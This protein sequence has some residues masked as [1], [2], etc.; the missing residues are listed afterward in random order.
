MATFWN[1]MSAEFLKLRHS[2]ALRLIWLFPALFLVLEFLFF[3]RPMLSLKVQSPAFSASFDTQQLKIIG[4]LWA[5]FFHPLLAALLP[6]LLFRNEHRCKVWRHLHAMPVPRRSIFLA[7]A[8]V[9]AALS[10]GAFS[11]VGLGLGLERSLLARIN[12]L[13]AFPWH[14]WEMAKVFGVLWIG[15]LPLFALYLWISDRVNSLAVPIV[16]GVI[17]LLLTIALGGSELAQPWKRDLIPWVLPYFCAQEAVHNYTPKETA[18]IATKIFQEEPNVL[19]L[20][21]GRKVKTWQNIPDDVLFPPPQPTPLWVL[22]T[23][24]L[25]AGVLLLGVGIVDSGRNRI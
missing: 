6:A 24:G 11:L 1:L 8:A 12:P 13:L 3:E 10:L 21:N 2:T 22:L 9:L 7:K 4:A 17:G 15:S 19:R 5:G 23:F 25:G 14:G 18:H 16:F 20:P